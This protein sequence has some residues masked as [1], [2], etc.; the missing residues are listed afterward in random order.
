MEAH[1]LTAT[2]ALAKVRDGSLTIEQYAQSLLGRIE[3]RDQA[4]KAWAYLDVQYVL[5]EA[6]RLD[7]VPF[8]ERGPLHGLPVAVKDI[9]YTKDMPTQ[10]NS[11][12]HEGD[13]P[14]LD[15]APV[16]ILREAG[17]LFVGKT[18]TTEFATAAG[19]NKTHNPHDPSRTPGGSSSGSAAAVADFQVP[20]ALGSQTS[21]SIVRPASFCGIYGF[22]PTFNAVSREGVKLFASSLDTVGLFSRSLEDLEALAAMFGLGDDDDDNH[23]SDGGF[24]IAGAR[25]GLVKS[26]AWSSAGPGTVVALSA[27]ANILRAHGAVVEEFE[28][29]SPFDKMPQWYDTL[30]RTES[31][32]TFL[33][34]Y[35]QHRAKL[36][37]YL[38]NT[39]EKATGIPRISRLEA[40]DGI[41]ALRP[42]IDDLI[43]QGGYAAILTPSVIDEAPVGLESTGSPVFNSMWTALHTPVVNIPGFEGANGMPIGVSLIGPRFRDRQLLAVCR[44]VGEIFEAEGGWKRVE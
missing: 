9:M 28:L 20:V 27:A 6:K 26:P 42:V 34:Q 12:I 32:T 38:V 44:A 36:S 17:V 30:L 18:T 3:E 29:P 19:T 39:V 1:K 14:R 37:P 13:A 5:R 8:E 15:A 40:S 31:A 16:M 11:P 21:G 33:P 4:V 24:G 43:R 10:H 7:Q 22:K 25:F 41:A 35:R 23:D 2:Q